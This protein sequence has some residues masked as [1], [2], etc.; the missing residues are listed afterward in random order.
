MKEIDIHIKNGYGILEFKHKFTFDS[1]SSFYALYAQNGTMKSSFAKVLN[2]YSVGEATKD[3]LFNIPGECSVSGIANKDILS[4]PCFDNGA[5]L[6]D[7]AEKLVSNDEAKKAYDE[8]LKETEAAYTAFISKLLETTQSKGTDDVAIVEAMYRTFVDTNATPTITIPAIIQLLKSSTPEIEKGSGL[9]ADVSYARFTHS[10]FTK[11]IE[12]KK[13]LGFFEELAKAY[14]EFRKSPTYYRKGFD[15][16]SATKLIKELKDSKYFDAEHAVSL[17][18]AQGNTGKPIQTAKDL[19]AALKTDL[20]IILEEYPHLK[21]QLNALIK[22]FSVGTNGD[23]RTIFE[24]N[25]KR[26]LLVF[27]GNRDRF[28]KN[29]WYGYLSV[30]Q[31]EIANLLET[32]ERS[33]EKI[34]KALEEA[35]NAISEWE[36]VKDIFN[37]RFRN[38]PY[39]IHITNKPDAIVNDLIK[40]V[41][42]VRFENPRDPS[43]P[44][45]EKPDNYNRLQ[46][47]SSILSN[48]ER[49]ALYLLNVIFRLRNQIKED[50]ETLIIFDDIIESFDYKNKYAFFEYLQDLSEEDN[51]LYTIVLTHNFDFYRLIYEK[52][53]PRNDEQFKLIL[54]AKNGDLTAETMFN[55]H[56]FSD[57]KERASAGDKLAWAAL[58]PLARNITEYKHNSLHAHYLELTKCLHVMPSILDIGSI[59][60]IIEEYTGVSTNP[61]SNTDVVHD[62]LTNSADTI[63]GETDGSFD[64]YKNFVLAMAIRIQIERYIID[65]ITDVQYQGVVAK[66]KNQTRGLLKVYYSN[67]PDPHKQTMRPL[68]NRAVMIIDG[69]IHINS[70]MYEPLVD[71]GTWELKEMYSDIVDAISNA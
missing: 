5:E 35:E 39:E 58:I 20:D 23:V 42:E 71:M 2:D 66:S 21:A 48:G 28:Y 30:C 49:K 27:M 1:N 8:A 67:S 24:D 17:K 15:A 44:Y 25:T 59:Q 11:F 65:H 34:K 10:N 40:P 46:T 70:F 18:D 32:H 60:P 33:S 9:F 7:E 45:R 31:E 69:S 12:N 6:S 53:H 61:F 57:I 36:Q 51:K 3:K 68:F 29:M 64:L 37:E 14:D 47:L 50:R 56:I 63:S 4:F 41:F 55:P 13:Y 19:E 16:S 62:I 43:S 26:Q 22:D 38:L 54:K 52:I